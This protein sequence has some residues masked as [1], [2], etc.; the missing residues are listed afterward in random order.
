MNW[1]N[2]SA[3]PRLCGRFYTMKPE[4]FFEKSAPFADSPGAEN[5]AL[6]RGDAELQSNP[7]RLGAQ[8]APLCLGTLAG[9]Q[10]LEDMTVRAPCILA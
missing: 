2:I 5:V 8:P 9:E 4:T 7:L 3:P 1:E 10:A 6:R